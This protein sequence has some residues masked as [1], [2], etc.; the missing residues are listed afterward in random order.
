MI[1][2]VP[3]EIFEPGQTIFF[4]IARLAQ[5]EKVMGT[6]LVKI[7]Q[8]DETGINFCLAGLMIGMKHH[9]P[10]GTMPFFAEQLDAFFEN[11]GTLI[12]VNVPIIEAIMAVWGTKKESESKNAQKVQKPAK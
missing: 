2:V 8:N 12:E 7:L 10:R 11:G 3:F 6:S 9:Y 1:K 4:D 5:F